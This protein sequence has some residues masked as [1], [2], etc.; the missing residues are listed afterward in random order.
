MKEFGSGGE[1]VP[2]APLIRH[3]DWY[4]FNVY[5]SL[6]KSASIQKFT[7]SYWMEILLQVYR[8]GDRSP[9]KTY[10]TDPYQEDA[11]PQ[12]WGQLTQVRKY[13]RTTC[14]LFRW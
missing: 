9:T 3:W 11:W 8:H 7:K 2:G 4:I 6:F 13:V 10:P 1:A 12:G 5:H 14:L